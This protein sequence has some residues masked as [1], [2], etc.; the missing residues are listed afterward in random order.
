MPMVKS[1][2][3]DE[4]RVFYAWQ[5][6]LPAKF[7]RTTDSARCSSEI[8]WRIDPSGGNLDLQ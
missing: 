4:I 3:S 1:K 7:T 2:K 6:D 5:S 8:N